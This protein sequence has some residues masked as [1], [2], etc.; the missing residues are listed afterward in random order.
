MTDRGLR[1]LL[2]DDYRASSEV[3]AALL[4]EFG[5]DVCVSSGAESA[6]AATEAFHPDVIILDLLMR[7]LDGFE[8]AKRLSEKSSCADAV[9]VAYTGAADD[10]IERCRAAGFQYVLRKPASSAQFDAVLRAIAEGR[11]TGRAA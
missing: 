3:L 9:Y 7:D 2:V 6:L 5:H 1:I 11:L 10:V 8:T 4:E